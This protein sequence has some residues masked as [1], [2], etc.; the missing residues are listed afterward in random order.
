[1]AT[2]TLTIK[3]SQTRYQNLLLW[4]AAFA[5]AMPLTSFRRRTFEE[6]VSVDWQILLRI[7]P[8][9]VLAVWLLPKALVAIHRSSSTS[10][11]I[12]WLLFVLVRTALLLIS[13]NPLYGG[14]YLYFQLTASIVILGLSFLLNNNSSWW[15]VLLVRYLIV[16]ITVAP[17]AWLINP[18]SLW[19][20]EYTSH[21]TLSRYSGALIHPFVAAELGAAC[22]G[23]VFISEK[24][25][26][27]LVWLSLGTTLC[28]LSLTKTWIVS[29]TLGVLAILWLRKSVPR[30]LLI[31]C[32]LVVILIA[33]RFD[34]ALW[35]RSGSMEEVTSLTG[36]THIW[37]IVIDYFFESP[38]FGY[39][40]G[41]SRYILPKLTKVT[42]AHNLW[43]QILLEGGIVLF[44][45]S[46]LWSWR[47]FQAICQLLKQQDSRRG[48][49]L[50]YFG[51][52]LVAASMTTMPGIMSYNILMVGWL[53]I[54][55]THTCPGG[56]KKTIK[57]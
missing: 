26:H 56:V 45:F 13:P 33:A 55:V 51:M 35:T 42:H 22:I 17:V 23:L 24:R 32:L 25:L 4:L 11:L 20:V 38:L 5:L 6:A 12:T 31:S 28:A 40:T 47:F 21:G 50:F 30:L 49:L 54:A 9:G 7:I 37:P 3:R 8:L 34:F 43:L 15:Q 48:V 53:T 57:W 27:S 2:Q 46:I 44:F 41:S 1:M 16:L 14:M 29:A 18:S 10:L 36:R 19:W 39:G 52:L